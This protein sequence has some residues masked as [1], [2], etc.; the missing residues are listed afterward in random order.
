MATYNG[1]KYIKEQLD[2][3]IN[4]TYKDWKLIICDDC[5]TDKTY[6]ILKEYSNKYNSK[7]SIFR[8]TKNSGSPKCNFIK[9]MIEH[10]DEYVM[11]CDQDDIWFSNKIEQTLQ[12]MHEI[13]I[14]FGKE[15]PV[16][17]HTDLTVVN[18][19]LNVISESFKYSTNVNYTKTSLNNVIIQNIL[20]GC[21]SMYNYALAKLI[22]TEPKN[23]VMHDWWLILIASAFGKVAYIN[24]P[25]I[26]YR[27]HGDNDIG[28]KNT[29][30]IFFKIGIIINYK[31]V[32][33]AIQNTYLQAESFLNI[34]SN[35][36]TQN[37]KQLLTEYISI[38]KLNKLQKCKKIIKLKTFKNGIA[39]KIA[40]FIYI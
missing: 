4:Q 27:Q 39:R 14:K 16:V 21:T 15:T 38:P 23:F 7:I 13:E 11:L 5:S 19:S 37:Q 26:F 29:R 32:K 24:N 10:K 20:A 40:Q 9:L 34:Y 12:K 25:T 22:H 2:S 6:D 36:L 1:D 28:A 33:L 3:I 18:E 17:I 31:Y 8:N 30:N 35:D